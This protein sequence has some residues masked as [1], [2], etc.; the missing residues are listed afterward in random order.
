MHLRPAAAETQ[1]RDIG[2]GRSGRERVLTWGTFEQ[3]EDTRKPSRFWPLQ[4]ACRSS[5]SGCRRLKPRRESPSATAIKGE[6]EVTLLKLKM[7]Y[8]YPRRSRNGIE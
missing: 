1:A 2:C 3:P 7:R 6:L 4:I 8:R 5:M